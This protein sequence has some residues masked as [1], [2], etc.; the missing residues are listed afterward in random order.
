MAR[1]QVQTELERD[2][3]GEMTSQVV[4]QM[5]LNLHVTI[6]PEIVV[7]NIGIVANEPCEDHNKVHLPTAQSARNESVP[8]MSFGVAK[9]TLDG[10]GPASI[11]RR[12]AD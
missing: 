1:A 5:Q 7:S 10:W 8:G 4:E 6:A 12:V 2:V 3:A 9:M 11:Q